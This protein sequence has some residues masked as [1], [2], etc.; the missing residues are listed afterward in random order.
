MLAR[1]E[2]SEKRRRPTDDAAAKRAPRASATRY[3]GGLADARTPC[4]GSTT[5][6]PRWGSLHA[7]R[8]VDPAVRAAAGD[9]VVGRRLRARARARA[10][11]RGR[12]H[13][14]SSGRGW[15]ATRKAERAKGYLQ[16]WSPA[17]QPRAAAGHRGRVRRRRRRLTPRAARARASATSST[18]S[19]CGSGS[20]STGHQRTSSDSSLTACAGAG[21]R[22]GDEPYVEVVH[23]A[24]RVAERHRVLARAA[25]APGR[26][27]RP[28]I[29]DSSAASRSAAPARVRVAG[30]AVAAELEPPP[31]LGCRVSSTCVAVGGRAPGRSA[32]RWSG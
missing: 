15:T 17:A 4:A 25:P 24:A 1:L 30:L 10:P 26:G 5:R 29:P 23:A 16:G 8:P 3:L 20:A 13:A 18:M 6:T 2:R 28:A 7:R 19:G 9:A 31:R 12:A 32:V 27:R 14:A 22:D 21:R 11:A